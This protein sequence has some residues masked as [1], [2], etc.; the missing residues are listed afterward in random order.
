MGTEQETAEAGAFPNHWERFPAVDEQYSQELVADQSLT[1]QCYGHSEKR[2]YC[3]RSVTP[4][5]SG[6]GGTRTPTPFGT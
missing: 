4:A 3:V 1:H 6:E 2:R 5:K